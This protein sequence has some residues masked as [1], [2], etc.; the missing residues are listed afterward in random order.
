MSRALQPPLGH[1][2]RVLL[3]LAL[4]LATTGARAE[5]KWQTYENCTLLQNE[6]NDGDSFHV[7]AGGKEYIFRLYFV[8]TPE[9]DASIPDRVAE[10][11]KYFHVTVP[12]TLQ[13]G[14]EAERFTRARLV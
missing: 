2:R 1:L 14:I 8:D 10:Q 12:Q 13:I 6:S 5:Q 11:A 3:A 9:T 4:S 7:R